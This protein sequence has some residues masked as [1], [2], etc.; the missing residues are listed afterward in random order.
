MIFEKSKLTKIQEEL[1]EYALQKYKEREKGKIDENLDEYIS[2]NKKEKSEN[3]RPNEHI[4]NK[5]NNGEIG[6]NEKDNA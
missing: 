4:L 5:N 2:I 1:T 3:G 6:N